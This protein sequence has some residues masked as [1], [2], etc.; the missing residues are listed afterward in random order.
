MKDKTYGAIALAAS[1]SLGMVATGL[2]AGVDTGHRVITKMQKERVKSTANIESHTQ[3]A[4]DELQNIYNGVANYLTKQQKTAVLR[5]QAASI[6]EKMGIIAARIRTVA[7]LDA[8][9]I[10]AP[11][12]STLNKILASN[13][14]PTGDFSR[15]SV[16]TGKQ[17]TAATAA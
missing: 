4:T 8:D 11:L 14:K 15:A 17:N 6:Q 10:L 9:V 1:T 16:N 13:S 2:V 5:E 12:K 3:V 7:G